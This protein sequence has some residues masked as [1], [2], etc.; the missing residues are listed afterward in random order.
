MAN[1]TMDRPDQHSRDSRE[2][3]ITV[4]ALI[5]GVAVLVAV[6]GVLGFLGLKEKLG[7]TSE[8]EL[9]TQVVEREDIRVTVSAGGTLQAMESHKV[10]S[11]VEGST[12]ILEVIPEGSRITRE[13]VEE[14][15]TLMRLDASQTRDNL[16]EQKI[17]V[18]DAS[19]AYTQ[20]KEE[21]DVQRNQNQSDISEA[22][23]DV[24][25]GRMELE[26]YL[27]RELAGAAI[28]DDVDFESGGWISRIGGAAL[29][30][31][32]DCEN[33]VSLAQEE[34][35]RTHDS[36]RWTR[37]LV[38]KGYVNRDE[39]DADELEQ[40]RR[41]V[42]LERAETELDLFLE[43]TLVREAQEKLADYEEAKNSLERTEARSRSRMAQAEADLK[44]RESTYE[45]QQDRLDKLREMVEKSTIKATRPGL[46]V[47]ASTTNPRRF[48][49]DPVQEGLSVREGQTIL[50]VPDLSTL[51]ARVEVPEAQAQMVRVDQKAEITVD[52]MP[53]EKWS[54]E[55][56]SISPMATQ[57]SGFR[58]LTGGSSGYETDVAFENLDGDDTEL[59]P[60]MSASVEIEITTIEDAPAVPIHAVDTQD[61]R[62]VCWVD[63]E[64]GLEI[65]EV[66]LGYYTD[67]HVHV[68]RGLEEGDRVVLTT[69][70][71]TPRDVPFVPLD[72][73]EG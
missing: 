15:V 19:A 52:A 39:L 60:G 16:D 13:D 50:T 65:R 55:V 31:R 48:R 42:E 41:E 58:A 51:A 62:R 21:Y 53:D 70:D 45:M 10:K 22:R 11:E 20:A 68:Q 3:A 34:L 54:G 46:I 57:Q 18:Q 73:A 28:N 61:G 23:L 38:E 36:L 35:S 47:Y 72:R 27:G 63:G 1:N 25:F 7:G 29:Q 71:R 40:K 30:E 24:R 32:R 9:P 17:K 69:P 59:K 64:D 56:R 6:G 66:Q 37:E 49:N 26:R 43:Y 12:Q 14:G 5:A 2:A 67:T 4:Y 8:S 44:S 33:E